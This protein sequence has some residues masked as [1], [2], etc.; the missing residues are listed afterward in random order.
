MNGD[1]LTGGYQEVS[2]GE[3]EESI[4]YRQGNMHAKKYTLGLKSRADVTRSP[5]PGY[6]Y[7]CSLT[8]KKNIKEQIVTL[9]AQSHLVW[10]EYH[11]V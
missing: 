5:K 3:C 8:T 9:V 11:F 7:K 2:R 4:T 10:F 1:Q 6:G